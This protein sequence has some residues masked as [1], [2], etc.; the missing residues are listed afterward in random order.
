M[1][2]P[3]NSTRAQPGDDTPTEPINE[4]IGSSLEASSSEEQVGTGNSDLASVP[5]SYKLASILLVSAIRFGSSWSSGITRVMKTAIKKVHCISFKML[6][7]RAN[8]MNPGDEYQ[9]YSICHLR[10]K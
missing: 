8:K 10:R 1:R 4:K 2:D 7:S 6:R 9:Q 3:D 5:P